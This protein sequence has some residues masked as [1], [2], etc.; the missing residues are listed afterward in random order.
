MKKP[1]E[2]GMGGNPEN[3]SNDLDSDATNKQ[4]NLLK[5]KLTSKEM[6]PKYVKV[7]ARDYKGKDK[8]NASKPQAYKGDPI[9]KKNL[10]SRRPNGVF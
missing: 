6:L 3:S 4:E 8:A 9:R 5:K 7:M 1:R 2:P 10:S